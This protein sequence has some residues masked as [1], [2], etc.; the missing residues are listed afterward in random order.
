METIVEEIRRKYAH[1]R[2]IVPA[3]AKSAATMMAM[4]ADEIILDEDAELGP[5]DP[6]MILPTGIAPAEAVKEQFE[7]AS[8]DLKAD[9]AKITVWMPILQ[10]M[11]PSLLVQCDNAIKLSRQLVEEWLTKYMFK[12]DAD[13]PARAA[14]VAEYLGKHSNFSSHARRVKLEQLEDPGRR[15]GLRLTNLRNDAVLYK[16]VWEVYCV[17]DIMFANTPVYKMFY[18]SLDDAIVRTESTVLVEQKQAP[19]APGTLPKL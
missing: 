12:G 8:K 14:A 3:Y 16:L 5:I 1:V 2:F 17:M 13:G 6:Q 7:K 4:S 18:N 15:F 19:G 11:G 9:P 10:P